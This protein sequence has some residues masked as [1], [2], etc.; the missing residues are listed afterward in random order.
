MS[1]SL[2][3]FSNFAFEKR[4]I[5]AQIRISKEFTFEMAHALLNYDGLCKHIH[6]HSYKLKVTIIGEPIKDKNNPKLG[7]VMDFSELK[8]IVRK[9]IITVFDH[10]FVI[11]KDSDTIEKEHEMFSRTIV[12]DYQPTSENM[13]EDFANRIMKHLP[14]NV[15][16]HNLR[17][18]ET[19][20]SYAEWYA[21]DN[22]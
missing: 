4:D 16:L 6:G 18:H 13:I 3:L 17:L 19:A 14:E 12:V 9:E 7:M 22:A 2:S 10:A 11:N 20:N 8:A 15:K 5:M 21:S 1:L